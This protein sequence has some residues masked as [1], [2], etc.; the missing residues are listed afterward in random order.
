MSHIKQPLTAN[1]YNILNMSEHIAHCWGDKLDHSTNT[2]A[3]PRILLVDDDEAVRESLRE[4]LEMPVSHYD[5]R[6]RFRGYSSDRH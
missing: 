5:S 4:V 2:T 3:W 6:E 1:I